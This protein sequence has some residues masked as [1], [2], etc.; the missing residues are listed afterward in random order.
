MKIS[1]RLKNGVNLAMIEVTEAEHADFAEALG[2]RN[3]PFVQIKG[4]RVEDPLKGEA[5]SFVIARD[6]ISDIFMFDA[7]MPE[8]SRV[9]PAGFPPPQMPR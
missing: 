1:I 9:M 8:Q 5:C 4:V 7:P 6:M 2:T 3:D